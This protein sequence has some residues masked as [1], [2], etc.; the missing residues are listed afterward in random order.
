M[1]LITP[2]PLLLKTSGV[3]EEM[4]GPMTHTGITDDDEKKGTWIDTYTEVYVLL[5]R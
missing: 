3:R 4:C 5:E 2:T 1:G